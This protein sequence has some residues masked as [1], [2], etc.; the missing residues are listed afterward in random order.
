MI[1]VYLNAV[2]SLAAIGLALTVV[3]L[4]HRERSDLLDRIQNP[5]QAREAEP[6]DGVQPIAEAPLP[7]AFPVYEGD[8]PD[9][10]LAVMEQIN[11][12]PVAPG[13]PQEDN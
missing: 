1:P 3:I 7:D 5:Y 6:G 9:F 13:Y 11:N 2:I 10:D 4:H 12:M 8:D